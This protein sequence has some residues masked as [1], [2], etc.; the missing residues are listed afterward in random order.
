MSC[1][2]APASNANN[3]GIKLNQTNGEARQATIWANLLELNLETCGMNRL[4][5]GGGVLFVASLKLGRAVQI[6]ASFHAVGAR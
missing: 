6:V 2:C 5:P 4:S 3:L 1:G